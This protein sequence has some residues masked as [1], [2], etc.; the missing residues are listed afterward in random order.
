MKIVI[1]GGAGYIGTTLIPLLLAEGHQVRV[2]DNLSYGGNPLIP[3][4][5]D[6]NFEFQRGDVR[7][8]EEVKEAVKGQDVVIHLAAIV[9]YPACRKNPKLAE[10]VHVGGTQN[11][12]DATSKSQLI[13]YASTS[14]NYGEVKEGVCTEETPLNPLSL[15]G[16]TKTLGEKM[17]LD[18]R[19]TIAYRFATAFGVSPRMRLDLLV[20]DFAYKAYSEGYLVVYEKHFQRAFIHVQ[21]IARGFLFGLEN[22]DKMKKD[23]FNMGSK[24]ANYNKEEI[25][26]IL[27]GKLKLYV[28][29]AEFGSDIDKRN[30][31]ISYDKIDALG[32]RPTI[33]LEEGIDEL[34][35]TFE[36]LDVRNQYTNI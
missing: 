29:Y 26:E 34:I 25:C 19:D 24:D 7:N 8:L 35:D 27:K 4:F 12:I 16:E 20:N 23:V 9:G 28:H 6:K 10:E 22:A 32:Y 2:F 36:V 13:F 3:F 1:T 11:V 15:Y 21:D 33:S 31:V 30:Y 17:L 14:S 18:S 5:R